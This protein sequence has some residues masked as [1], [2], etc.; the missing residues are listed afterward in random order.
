[1]SP[2]EFFEPVD[3]WQHV[4]SK[5]ITSRLKQQPYSSHPPADDGEFT[6]GISLEEIKEKYSKQSEEF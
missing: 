1:M 3:V 4:R 5:G 2:D 6:G